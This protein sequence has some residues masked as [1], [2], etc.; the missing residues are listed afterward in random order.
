VKSLS[1]GKPSDLTRSLVQ[2]S[3]NYSV[4]KRTGPVGIHSVE[5]PFGVISDIHGNYP[6]AEAALKAHP[7]IKQWFCLGDVVDY[8]DRFKNNDSTI[9]WWKG[10]HI[11]TILGN[12]DRDFAYAF[13]TDIKT[14]HWIHGLPHSFK[15]LL[16]NGCHILAYH[17]KPRDLVTFVDP[18][19]SE[20]EFVDDYL[21]VTDDTVAVL[22]GHNHKQFKSV[23]PNCSASLWSVGSVGLDGEYATIDENGINFHRVP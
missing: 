5:F 15:L 13:R 1:I 4:S 20:R 10:S 7:E 18:G 2:P 17:S 22:I 11:P 14:V 16:P 23:F 6:K 21:D 12:H 19:Y 3:D 8:A 9:E